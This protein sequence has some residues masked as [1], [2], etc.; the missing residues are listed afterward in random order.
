VAKRKQSLVVFLALAVSLSAAGPRQIK[1]GWNLF[2]KQQDIELGREAAAQVE[3]QMQVVRDGQLQ[4]YIERIGRRLVGTGMAGDYPYSFKV[5]ND[6]SIN[7]FA[8]PGGPTFV[9]T[10]LLRAADNEAQVAE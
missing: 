1:P 8:L 10:G 2:S 9:N 6:Q 7:A 5:V 3:R 4:S